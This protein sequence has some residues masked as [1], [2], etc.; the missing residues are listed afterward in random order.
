MPSMMPS[1]ETLTEMGQLYAIVK[2][3]TSNI[4]QVKQ[5]NVVLKSE[6]KSIREQLF[7]LNE[8][9]VEQGQTLQSLKS[10]RSPPSLDKLH[11]YTEEYG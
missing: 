10:P 3:L 9:M 2:Q 7:Q 6:L 1:C 8:L 5:E 4:D 11:E